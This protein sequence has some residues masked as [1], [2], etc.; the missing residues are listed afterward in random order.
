MT[1]SASPPSTSRH[2]DSRHSHHSTDDEDL[3]EEVE[4]EEEVDVEQCSDGEDQ[5]ET[6]LKTFFS[7]SPD[8]NKLERLSLVI[9]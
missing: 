9:I 8:R 1:S 7:S 3:D 4:D 2:S 6:F 5:V